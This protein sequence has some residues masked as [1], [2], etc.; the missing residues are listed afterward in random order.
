MFGIF[1]WLDGISAIPGDMK[2]V[3]S[4]KTI[5]GKAI[6]IEDVKENIDK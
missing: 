2:I 3:Q 4:E 6:L 1:V 5:Y